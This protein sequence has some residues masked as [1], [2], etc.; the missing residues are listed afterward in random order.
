MVPRLTFYRSSHQ[1]GSIPA[2][3]WVLLALLLA[4]PFAGARASTYLVRPD[5]SGDFPTIQSALDAAI[6][7]DEVVLAD[8]TF[9]GES[10][11][12]FHGKAL[13]LHS[14]SD[15]PAVCV[16]APAG[17]GFH[18]HSGE[19]NQARIEGI[20]ILHGFA[21]EWDYG[22]GAYLEGASPVFRNCVFD[23]CCATH[24]NAVCAF[25][26]APSFLDCE[27]AC[28]C[29]VIP[30]GTGGALYASGSQILIDGC[31]FHFLGQPHGGVMEAW[32][33]QITATGSS[34]SGIISIYDCF[35]LHGCFA[36]FSACTMTGMSGDV[37]FALESTTL[38]ADH[39]LLAYGGDA[40]ASIS[41]T[42]GATAQFSCCD[43]FGLPGGNWIDCLAGQQNTDHN[44][45]ADPYLCEWVGRPPVLDSRSRCDY[46]EGDLRLR[47]DSPCA[48][49]N[50]PSCGRIGAFDVACIAPVPVRTVAWGQIKHLY[51]R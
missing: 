19:T 28:S 22:G 20:T 15:D 9:E 24:G 12:D 17:R 36:S 11:L 46:P 35:L 42:G 50:N 8:G 51:R 29:I 33:C 25:G 34:F 5:G 32:N 6:G 2:S 26:G 43:I 14:A 1:P 38:V 48:A 7:G 21:H 27:F 10:N 13:F 40:T 37:V 39:S 41:C 31:S 4:S 3:R 18:L 44:L 23:N 30:D 16:Y 47:S 49:E 45:C